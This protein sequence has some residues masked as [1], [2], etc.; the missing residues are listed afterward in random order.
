MKWPEDCVYKI[1]LFGRLEKSVWHMILIS[2][3]HNGNVQKNLVQQK[4][5]RYNKIGKDY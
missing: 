4:E 5:Q 1:I 3:I 2:K